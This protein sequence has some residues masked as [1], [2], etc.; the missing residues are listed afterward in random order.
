MYNITRFKKKEISK[1][2]NLKTI[3]VIGTNFLNTV[4]MCIRLY[5]M[6]VAGRDYGDW[7]GKNCF[8]SEVFRL[9]SRSYNSHKKLFIIVFVVAL[10]VR[11][12]WLA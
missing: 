3:T 10:F 11:F 9:I 2:S 4:K 6:N 12:S 8:C 1:A 7:T 5:C